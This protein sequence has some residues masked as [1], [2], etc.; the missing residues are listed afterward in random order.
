[1]DDSDI[2]QQ[3]SE[4]VRHAAQAH[5]R[6]AICG[7]GTK[8]FYA[9]DIEGDSLDVTGHCG[10]VSYEPTELIVTARA[11][12]TLRELEAALAD[13]GQML[14]FEPP[15]F[16]EAATLGGTIACGFSGPRRPY[17]GAA[18]D[19]VLGT[20]IINGKGEILHFGGEVMKNVAGYDV[21]RL[22]VGALGS[23]GVLLEVSL[24]VLPKPA[25]EVTLC[26]EMPADKGIS[27]MNDL[28]A[29]PLPL[30]ATCHAGETLYIRLS[31]TELGIHAARAKLGG[32]P[33]DKSEDF[34]RDIREH[35]RTFFN[36]DAPL[37]RLSVP[38][39]TPVINLPGQ[40][41]LDWG[42]AQRWL[43]SAAPAREIR[44]KAESVGGHATLFRQG[45][46]NGAQFHP[47]PAKLAALNQSLKRAFDPNGIINRAVATAT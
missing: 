11:G 24:K 7:G 21:S 18:R 2:S 9:G 20:R 22:M 19:F 26:F 25:R 10:I 41:L 38:P 31:G 36:D 35:R 46:M 45:K 12:T 34:W 27:I 8:R 29:Q 3:L 39:A 6:L 16:G 17:A 44:Q 37:W 1:M 40:W 28:G 5:T 47:L 13:K 32:K 30:S 14:A 42:G 33:M 15:W 4:T 23:L 43:K